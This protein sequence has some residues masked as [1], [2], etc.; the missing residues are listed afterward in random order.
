MNYPVFMQT[1]SNE[2]APNTGIFVDYNYPQSSP[3]FSVGSEL[4]RVGDYFWDGVEGVWVG[5]KDEL[6]DVR[7]GAIDTVDSV[8]WVG[9]K[10]VLLLVAGVAVL[11]WV[12]GKS[13]TKFAIPGLSVG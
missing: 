7:E 9:V 10:Y 2:L 13:G 5:I 8:L 1:P 12:L 3:Q 4:S 6:K 11:V